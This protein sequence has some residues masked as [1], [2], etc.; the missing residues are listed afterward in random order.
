V[1]DAADLR[2]PKTHAE[3]AP[4]TAVDKD[5]RRQILHQHGI[6]AAHVAPIGLQQK[7]L[8]VRLDF[9]P[10]DRG[11]AGD[12]GKDFERRHC[13]LFDF[14]RERAYNAALYAPV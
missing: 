14:A 10:S 8:A 4:M 2:L 3:G 6:A 11:T 7:R 12:C 13:Q 5:R 9:L 1:C